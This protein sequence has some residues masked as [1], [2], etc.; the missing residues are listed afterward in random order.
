M[1]Q[2]ELLYYE[3]AIMHEINTIN[4]CN[5]TINRLE[6]KDLVSFIKKEIKKHESIKE[7]LLNKLE[8]CINE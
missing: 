8:E 2:K 4:I 5:D 1:T 3:D 6:N 7:K